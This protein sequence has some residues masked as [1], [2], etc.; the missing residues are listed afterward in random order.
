MSSEANAGNGKVL[1]IEGLTKYFGGL[2]AVKDFRLTLGKGDLFGLI[3]PNGAGKTTVFNLITGLYA[4]SAGRVSFLGEPLA[5][6]SDLDGDGIERHR[7]RVEE[8]LLAATLAA[9]DWAEQIA[10]PPSRNSVGRVPAPHSAAVR[11]QSVPNVSQNVLV[12]VPCNH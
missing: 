3:G 9:E 5:V 8:A 1:E 11:D 12:E 6:P 2:C 10:S 4:L 7:R